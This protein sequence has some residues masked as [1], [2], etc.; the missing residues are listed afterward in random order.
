[1]PSWPEHRPVPSEDIEGHNV[2]A[3]LAGLIGGQL[4]SIS[5][6]GYLKLQP[7]EDASQDETGTRWVQPL[8]L[9]SGRT[10]R[11]TTELTGWADGA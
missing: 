3:F 5:S 2:T 11:V 8:R 10:L 1:M 9:A 6:D 4:A 7:L